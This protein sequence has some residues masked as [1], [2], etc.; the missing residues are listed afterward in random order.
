VVSGLLKGQI[1]ANDYISKNQAA[2]EQAANAELT[3][4]TGKGL[5][6]SILA[7][8]FKEITFTDDPIASSLA[9]DAKHAEAVGLLKPVNLSGIYD[10]GPLNTLLTAAGEPNV[11]S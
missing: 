8:S 11:S 4:L 5:K 3:K 9:T 10:L 1:Q 2:A 7:A 6:S